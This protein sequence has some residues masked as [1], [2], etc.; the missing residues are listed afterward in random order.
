[1]HNVNV[2]LYLY[3]K[4]WEIGTTWQKEEKREPMYMYI[5]LFFFSI[6]KIETKTAHTWM[7]KYGQTFNIL[8][9]VL[10]P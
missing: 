8:I 4:D 6:I 5:P 7:H 2:H 1:M 9:D 10:L 3:T